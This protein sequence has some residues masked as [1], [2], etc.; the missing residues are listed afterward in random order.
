MDFQHEVWTTK[1]AVGIPIAPSEVD[2]GD[3]DPLRRASHFRADGAKQGDV[4]AGRWGVYVVGRD[5]V[6]GYFKKMRR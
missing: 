2:S 3:D 1:P 5:K 4:A 6:G